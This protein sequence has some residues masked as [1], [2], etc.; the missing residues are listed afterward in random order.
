MIEELDKLD[1]GGLFKDHL[2]EFSPQSTYDWRDILY[3]F[4]SV[5]FCGGDCA[6]DL[7]GNLKSG[8]SQHP[9]LSV[10]S[11][12]RVLFRLKELAIQSQAFVTK[13]SSAEHLFAV[14]DQLNRLNL[15]LCEQLFSM[16]KKPVT[17]DYDNTLC[18][19]KKK[20]ATRTYKSEDGYQPG[21]AF[22]GRQVVYVENRTGNSSAHVGQHET[23]QRVFSLLEEQ[24][25][26]V[27]CFRAD[28]ASYGYEMIKV[29]D[30]FSDT[31]YIRARMSQSLERAISGITK[32]QAVKKGD[33][34]VQ[35]GETTFTPF[36]RA[37]RGS[38]VKSLKSYRLVVV[39]EKRRDGQLNFFTQEACFYSTIITN[40]T[41]KKA[42]DIIQ[43]YN[44]RGAIEREFEVLKYDF[45]WHKLPFSYLE[46]NNVYM[47]VTAMCRNLYDYMIE[48]FSGRIKY[49][50]PHYRIKKF[51]FRFICIPAK[52]VHSARAWY[53][54]LYGEI[55][56]KT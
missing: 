16:S 55:A 40:D 12:D 23:L 42:H 15:S 56:F 44:Q 18:Y 21:A 35:L 14:N 2:S 10:P 51:I 31:F 30:H 36:Q 50:Q 8:L 5:F 26:K 34:T 1:I 48:L 47:L 54:R 53:L 41:D 46:Q 3:S 52:W 28:S 6:E 39:K 24:G 11:P 37:A 17:L 25:V 33:E 19:T 7:G 29:I 13:R 22:I 49:L 43:F 27:G 32:W 4:W 38:E 45:G 9:N 20:D